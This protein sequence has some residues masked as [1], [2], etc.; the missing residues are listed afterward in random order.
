MAFPKIDTWIWHP[1][2][3]EGTI[4]SSAGGIVHFRRTIDVET[5][6]SA[7]IHVDIT[8]D[9]KYKFYINSHLVASGPVKGDEHL[10][11]YDQVNVQP[12]LQVGLNHFHIRVLRLDFATPFATSFPRLP[13]AGLLIRSNDLKDLRTSNEWDTAIDLTTRLLTNTAEDAFLHIYEEVDNRRLAETSWVPAKELEFSVSHGISAPWK[14]AKR[15]I[16]VSK[17]EPT[18]F[19]EIHNIRSIVARSHWEDALL[20]SGSKG[21]CLPAGTTHHVE[22]EAENHMTA[23][24]DFIFSRPLAAES[25]LKVLHTWS[26]YWHP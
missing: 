11:F 23:S 24:L 13:Q 15:M 16:P 12:F 25:I 21:L 26:E 4:T 8:A 14:L 3:K 22:L 10:W 19:K 7:P 9:T 1:N 18:K 5:L 6:P 17:L 20:G 2:W